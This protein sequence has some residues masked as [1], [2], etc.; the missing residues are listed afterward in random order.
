MSGQQLDD[1]F[2]NNSAEIIIDTE[3]DNKEIRL[4]DLYIDK[5]KSEFCLIVFF[6]RF[7]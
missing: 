5:N 1:L 2:I 6:T 3:N 4:E 7:G